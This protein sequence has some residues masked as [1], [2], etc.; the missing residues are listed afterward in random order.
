M[1]QLIFL[2]LFAISVLLL[3][4]PQSKNGSTT[5]TP[6][7][8]NTLVGTWCNLMIDVDYNADQK[9]DTVPNLTADTTNWEKVLDMKPIETAFRAD[10]SWESIYRNLKDSVIMRSKGKWWVHRDTL[11]MT[12]ERNA[13]TL[14]VF[15]YHIADDIAYFKGMIDFD[16]DGQS[17]DLY[18][19]TQRRCK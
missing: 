8:R 19:G 6:P 14:Y 5:A 4:A 17:D 12:S 2:S 13:K 18:I 16:E 7:T 1:K 9:G 15:A 3:A 11:V 10:S